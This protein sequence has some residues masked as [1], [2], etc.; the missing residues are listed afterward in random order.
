V[1][2]GHMPLQRKLV[3][4]SVLSNPPFPIIDFTPAP[5]D[6]SESS[7]PNRRNP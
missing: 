7:T 6:Q 1:P 2:L 3:K 4:Q 5:N